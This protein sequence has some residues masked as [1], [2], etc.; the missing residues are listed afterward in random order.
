MSANEENILKDL[1]FL[2]VLLSCLRF[3]PCRGEQVSA[4]WFWRSEGKSALCHFGLLVGWN[5]L[6]TDRNRTQDVQ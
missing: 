3:T 2:Q 4:S 1:A 5:T 6:L